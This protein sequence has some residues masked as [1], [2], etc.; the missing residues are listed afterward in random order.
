V[1]QVLHFLDDPARAIREAAA[2]LAPG[3]RLLVVDFAAHELEFLRERHGHRRLGFAL[4]Q[5]AGWFAEA[6]LD[7]VVERHLAPAAHER[8][9]LTVSLWL[10]QDRRVITDWPLR[11]QQREV[12]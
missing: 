3:G 10:A 11:Q 5:V 1:H 7:I 2:A 8:D 12:A 9:A 4:D 6:G